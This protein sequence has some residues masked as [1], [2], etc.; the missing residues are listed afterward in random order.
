MWRLTGVRDYR[1]RFGGGFFCLF[2]SVVVLL[3]VYDDVKAHQAMES[4]AV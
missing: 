4:V 2:F 3:V 1:K